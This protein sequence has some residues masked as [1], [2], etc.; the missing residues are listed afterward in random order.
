MSGNDFKGE[1]TLDEWIAIFRKRLG[2]DEPFVMHER[3]HVVYFPKDG[4]FTWTTSDTPGFINI[5][6][7]CGNGRR[8]RRIIYDFVIEAKLKGVCFSTRRIPGV[9]ERVLG[10]RLQKV[11]DVFNPETNRVEPF[12]SYTALPDDF[13]GRD[14]NVEND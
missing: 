13:K 1:K 7:M 5:H 14:K 6:K 11:T 8:L 4:F 2:A 3:E 10:V 12:Y 9:Y